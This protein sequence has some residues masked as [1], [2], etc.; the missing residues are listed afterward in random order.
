MS[1][2]FTKKQQDFLDSL[3]PGSIYV[4]QHCYYDGEIKC[5]YFV[6]S[7]LKNQVQF[8]YST[9]KDSNWFYYTYYDSDLILLYEVLTKLGG[10]NEYSIII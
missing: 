9:D 5:F 1:P 8:L 3:T 7:N 2:R 4:K 6:L 10:H